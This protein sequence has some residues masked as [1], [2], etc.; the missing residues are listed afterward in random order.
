MGY[1]RNQKL[2]TAYQLH[3]LDPSVPPWDQWDGSTELLPFGNK[4]PTG[5]DRKRVLIVDDE[6][7]IRLAMRGCLELEGYDVEEAADGR[8]GISAVVSGLPD[9]VIL[10]LAMPVLDGLSALRLLASEYAPIRP[11]VIVLTAFASIAAMERAQACGASAFVEKPVSPESLRATVQRVLREKLPAVS[12]RHVS[13][14]D[15]GPG[16]RGPFYG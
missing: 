2:E 9:V 13:E 6:P 14:E 12:H 11:R 15:D 3:L 8:A 1:A 4:T 10:D 16:A 5:P 7:R